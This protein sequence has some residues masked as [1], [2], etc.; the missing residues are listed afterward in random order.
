MIHQPGKEPVKLVEYFM[1]TTPGKSAMTQCL[2]TS[3]LSPHVVINIRQLRRGQ[4]LEWIT[5]QIQF[6]DSWAQLTTTASMQLIVCFLWLR[7]MFI[8]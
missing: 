8:F 7:E 3:K 6:A 5:S 1:E 4:H 2:N